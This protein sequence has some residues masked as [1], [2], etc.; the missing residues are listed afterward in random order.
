[1]L[2]DLS[3]APRSLTRSDIRTV[4]LFFFLSWKPRPLEF[5]FGFLLHARRLLVFTSRFSRLR[6]DLS[7]ILYSFFFRYDAFFV[8]AV[9]F[10]FFPLYRLKLF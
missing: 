4:P 9:A 7:F 2:R 1:M 3:S 5:F 10:F 8:L 6:I